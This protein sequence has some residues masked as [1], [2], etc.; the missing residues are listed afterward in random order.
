M[1]H[2]FRELFPV[3]YHH[4]VHAGGD[5]AKGDFHVDYKNCLMHTFEDLQPFGSIPKVVAGNL[6]QSIG[7][8]TVFMTALDRGADIL[9]S[10]EEINSDYLT[11]KC[12]NHLTKMHYCAGCN[13]ISKHRT[14]TCYGYCTNVMRYVPELR[15]E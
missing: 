4:A 12:R 9:E 14:K 5:S 13:G 8:A 7:A 11:T 2:F 3:A 10:A 6:I 15:M 1:T